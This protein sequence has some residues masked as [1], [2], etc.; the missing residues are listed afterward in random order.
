[1]SFSLNLPATQVNVNITIQRI[2]KQ[3]NASPF[4]NHVYNNA[5]NI[6]VYNAY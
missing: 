1:M 5:L 6:H 2:L 4:V 3:S